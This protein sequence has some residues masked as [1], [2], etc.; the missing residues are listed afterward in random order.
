MKTQ[1]PLNSFLYFILPISLFMLLSLGATTPEGTDDPPPFNEPQSHWEEA[2]LT[3]EPLN[4]TRILDRASLKSQDLLR[5]DWDLRTNQLEMEGIASEYWPRA[6]LNASLYNNDSSRYDRLSDAFLASLNLN[7]NLF[8]A[9][10]AFFRNKYLKQ[11]AT[12][13]ELAHKQALRKSKARALILYYNFWAADHCLEIASE[14]KSLE[15][16]KLSN[17][18]FALGKNL[19]SKKSASDAA[20]NFNELSWNDD[21]AGIVHA[22]AKTKLLRYLFLPRETDIAPPP[23][24]K[25]PEIPPLET[26]I[27]K[28]LETSEA[29]MLSRENL[30]AARQS[31][32]DNKYKRWTNFYTSFYAGNSIPFNPWSEQNSKDSV[33]Y[34]AELKWVL[35]LF[36]GGFYNRQEKQ[37]EIGYE[38]AL[39][40]DEN[41][42]G[43]I[44]DKITD[45]WRELTEKRKKIIAAEVILEDKKKSF[46]LLL[47]RY[48]SGKVS[49]IEKEEAFLDLKK[50]K[51]ELRIKKYEYIMTHANLDLFCGS[52]ISWI[53]DQE[54]PQHADSPIKK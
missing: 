51:I 32:R 9:W 35:P 40:D 21:N 2:S 5:E 30:K 45:L 29:L 34:A 27:R 50:K 49:L 54:N 6:D 46:E 10:K 42:P 22:R 13:R 39:L 16:K 7:W 23:E 37:A 19:I 47:D 15:A 48:G 11:N 20:E 17:S 4:L 24:I 26:F 36:D 52:D 25:I 18:E 8:N 12:F 31:I 38:K 33:F 28:T 44:V 3:K 43:E 41:L 53:R 14:E 1:E